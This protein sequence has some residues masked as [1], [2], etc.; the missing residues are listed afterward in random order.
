MDDISIVIHP[1][2]L[3]HQLVKSPLVNLVNSSEFLNSAKELSVYLKELAIADLPEE[4]SDWAFTNEYEEFRPT[5][6]IQNPRHIH[7]LV[8]FSSTIN[9]QLLY[10]F[11]VTGVI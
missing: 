7:T 11:D 9:T 3:A 5:E 1:N 2:N 10:S 6:Y 4:P 8:F